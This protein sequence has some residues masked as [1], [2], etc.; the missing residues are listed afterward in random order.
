MAQIDAREVRQWFEVKFEF[1]AVASLRFR[2]GMR[3][4]VHVG[5]DKE[6]NLGVRLHATG[7]I[8][9]PYDECGL[10]ALKFGEGVWREWE[11][12]GG[13]SDR[14]PVAISGVIKHLL[15]T[16]ESGEEPEL[17]A[18][19]ALTSTE[20]IFAAYE[21]ARR[22]AR[23]DLPIDIEDNPFL[24]MLEEGVIGPCD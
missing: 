2:N 13:P 1:A 3:A 5:D 14:G 10:R 17:S 23:I 12:E 8:L 22:R 7:G 18:A 16:L 4:M 15:D 9:E 6:I 24:S 20:A 11:F 19:K 21:S